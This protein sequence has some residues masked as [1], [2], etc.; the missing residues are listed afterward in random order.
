MPMSII[1]EEDKYSD[2]YLPVTENYK[3][4]DKFCRY[5]N[6]MS[7]D[8]NPM[9][10]VELTGL[11]YK[12]GTTIYAVDRVNG[13][14]YGKFSGGFRIINERAT[15]EQ[16]YRGASLAGIYGPAQPMH[17]STLPGMTQMVTPLAKSTPMTQSSQMPTISG[18]IPP[19]RYIVELT[20]IE[21]ARAEYLE[22]QMG[23]ISRL[24]SDIPSLED[25]LVQRQVKQR[26][27]AM[28]EEKYNRNQSQQCI[29]TV[30][31]DNLQERV[32]NYCWENKVKRKQEWESYRKALERM[33]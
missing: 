11:S 28:S 31:P 18:R 25:E 27:E 3:I 8:N 17:M 26:K 12:Y 22:R 30:V 2:L 23:S 21:Q 24:P 9:I 14:M 6:G 29:G 13:T 19:V 33:K 7:A 20:P 10:L 1:G 15:K 5:A 4:S 32:Q 16:Q